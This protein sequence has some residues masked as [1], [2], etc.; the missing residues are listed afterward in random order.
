MVSVNEPNIT[1]KLPTTHC[2]TFSSTLVDL[3]FYKRN[4]KKVK[5]KKFNKNRVY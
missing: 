2:Y 1:A 4:G 3:S 5:L